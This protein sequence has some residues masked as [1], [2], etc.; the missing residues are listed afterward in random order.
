M[1]TF[2]EA[3]RAGTAVLLDAA[4]ARVQVG[5]IAPDGTARWAAGEDEAGVA[6]F[7]ALEELGVDPGRVATW[8][9]C[10]GPGSI[11]G[12]RTVAMALRTWTLLRP[13]P[14]L[15]YSSLAVVAHALG[16][17][18]A[19]VIADAR[20]ECWHHLRAGEP[21]RRLPVAALRP[22]LFLPEYFRTWSR[23]PEGVLPA[24]YAW[25]D[26]LPRVWDADLLRP[27]PEPDA[28]LHED[29]VYV[30]WTPRIHQAPPAGA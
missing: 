11:L 29:P 30:T 26:L 27:A 18:E 28:F 15:A 19:A 6:V 23:L 17:P 20:R 10:E 21:L 14:V 8:L 25:P 24:P 4:S 12:I 3:C 13:V 9:F 16:R 2:R 5:L 7:R 22:P 1:P